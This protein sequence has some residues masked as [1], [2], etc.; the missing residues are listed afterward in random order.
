MGVRTSSAVFAVMRV[1]VLLIAAGPALALQVIEPA[2]ERIRLEPVTSYYCDPDAAMTIQQAAAQ[3]YEPLPNGRI[4]FGYHQ[5]QRC[6]FRFQLLNTST[7]QR[8]L[9]LD[10]NYGLIDELVLYRQQERGW[11][12]ERVGDAVPFLERPL[13]TRK[14]LFP[15]Q[16]APGE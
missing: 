5:A 2:F 4:S 14:N 12:S 13:D 16:L 15:I 1:M 9:I 6:W 7:E 3:T 10:V 11:A 8:N